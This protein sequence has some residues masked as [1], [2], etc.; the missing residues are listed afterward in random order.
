MRH[1]RLGSDEVGPSGNFLA[2]LG[3]PMLLR[4]FDLAKV[5]LADIHSFDRPGAHVPTGTGDGEDDRGR[6]SEADREF[7]RIECD[8]RIVARLSWLVVHG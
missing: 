1:W 3:C 4:A 2:V 8:C 7:A 6:D 5:G